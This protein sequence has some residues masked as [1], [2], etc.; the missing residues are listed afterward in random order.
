MKRFSGP[1]SGLVLSI[2]LGLSYQ[3]F[4]QDTSRE[5][6]KS[7]SD[8]KSEVPQWTYSGENGPQNW[9]DLSPDYIACKIGKNQSPVNVTRTADANLPEIKMEYR[10][11]IPGEIANN[12]RG[13]H[14][15]L[16]SGGT[17]TVDKNKY[18]LKSITFHSPSEHIVDNFDFPLEAQFLHVNER[19]E[20]V[21]ISLL[22]S[23]GPANPTLSNLIRELP[24][25]GQT[26]RLGAKDVE[27]LEVTKTIKDYFHYNG[28]L[29]YPPCTEGIHWLVLKQPA[30]VSKDQFNTIVK[31]MQSANRRPINPVNARIIL[32]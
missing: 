23:P 5:G 24:A 16:V 9:G 12:G 30:T 4:A 15:D 10:M 32:R 3:V 21:I 29:T 31:A 6:F 26:K 8:R 25:V 17:I 22:Y 28:S 1:V 7:E 14:L 11:L 27:D 18:E 13:L 2:M 20:K 19:N